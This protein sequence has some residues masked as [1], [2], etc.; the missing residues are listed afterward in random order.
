MVIKLEN[1][2]FAKNLLAEGVS[3]KES[4]YNWYVSADK[5]FKSNVEGFTDFA[6]ILWIEFHV[7]RFSLFDGTKSSDTAVAAKDVKVYMISG[8][9]CAMIQ[10]RLAKG[11]VIP[12]ITINKTA[13]LMGKIEIFEK[14]E[15]SQ[16]VIQSFSV[17][18]DVVSFSFRYS[19]YS[20]TYTD[21]DETGTNKGTAATQ[22]DLAKWEVKDS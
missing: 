9:H 11:V 17:A 18:G 15:F 2:F 3:N 14:K 6:R 13:V 8:P 4:S 22:I 7:S 21:F 20:D 16:C 5:I 19:S 12:K 1:P 10:G